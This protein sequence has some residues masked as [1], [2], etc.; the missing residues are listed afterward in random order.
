MKRREPAH[1]PK[2][3]PKISWSVWS[4]WGLGDNN[5]NTAANCRTLTKKP[6][7]AEGFSAIS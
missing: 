7:R 6:A 5:T 3:P 1:K 2:N 4:V